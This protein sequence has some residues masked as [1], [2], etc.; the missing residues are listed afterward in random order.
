MLNK[1]ERQQLSGIARQSI[2]TGLQQGQPLNPELLNFAPRLQQP[3]ASFVTLEKNHQ[4]RGC[5]GSLEAYQPLA[6]DVAQNAYAAAFR[7]P[8]F[9]PLGQNEMAA[10]EIH[11]SVLSQPEPMHVSSEADLL[12][13]IRPGKDGLI[14]ASG[15]HRGTFLPSVWEQLPRATEFVRHLKLK[16]GLPAEGWPADMQVSRYETESFAAT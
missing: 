3:G 14:F 13:Q 6:Q 7:D 9:P 15:S 2:E 8:R 16:A 5:I 1:T 11:I 4:L 12:A 10:L